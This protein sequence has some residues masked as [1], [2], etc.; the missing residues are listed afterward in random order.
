MKANQVIDNF[1]EVF[2]DGVSQNSWED[3]IGIENAID[4]LK[5]YLKLFI[6]RIHSQKQ[7]DMV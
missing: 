5:K 7:E 6:L 2:Y 4:E 1:I 3:V